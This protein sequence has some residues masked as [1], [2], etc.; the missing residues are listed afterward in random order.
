MKNKNKTQLIARILSNEGGIEP[1]S[2]DKL[3]LKLLGCGCS[4]TAYLDKKTNR[5]YKV[6]TAAANRTEWGF[7][8]AL[9]KHARELFAKPL[10]ISR[11]GQVLEMEFVDTIL[12]DIYDPMHSE[13][14]INEKTHTRL[15]Y[16]GIDNWIVDLHN[17]N[18]GIKKNRSVKIVDY[19]FLG[20]NCTTKTF[21][22]I[23][24]RLKRNK[25]L[26]KSNSGLIKLTRGQYEK[27]LSTTR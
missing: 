23:K 25:R 14:L 15:R 16:L 19:G 11:C 6:G 12:D 20:V 18:I 21:R 3:G 7:Y 2:L 4:R 8:R 5:V 10:A 13:H 27:I 24:S 1:A 22:Q 9:P 26:A 17:G